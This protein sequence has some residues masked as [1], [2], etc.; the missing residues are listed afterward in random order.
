MTQG[1][2]ELGREREKASWVWWDLLDSQ[3]FYGEMG[4]RDKGVLRKLAGQPD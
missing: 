3:L 1:E 4:G 2:G